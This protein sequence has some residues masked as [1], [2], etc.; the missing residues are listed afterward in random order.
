LKVNSTTLPTITSMCEAF[1][2]LH[3]QAAWPD[4]DDID[5]VVESRLREMNQAHIENLEA[6]GYL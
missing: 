2:P 6:K 3:M 4:A 1:E 5:S